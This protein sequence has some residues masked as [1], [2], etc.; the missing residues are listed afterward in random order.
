MN[1]TEILM[2]I[3]NRIYSLEN[4]LESLTAFERLTL[5]DTKARIDEL[6]QLREE[7]ENEWTH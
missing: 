6:K 4:K 3:D 1:K 2:H 7:I 5:N